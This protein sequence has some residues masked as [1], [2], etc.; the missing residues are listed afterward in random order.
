MNVD[1]VK[2]L[3]TKP[4]TS[5]RDA[6]HIAVVSLDVATTVYP[7]QRVGVEN[8]KIDPTSALLVGIVDPFL[9]NVPVVPGEKCFLY[10]FPGTITSLMHVW[11]HPDVP[12]SND[13]E[14]LQKR[15]KEL[16]SRNAELEE[17][18]EV[19]EDKIKSLEKSIVGE[20]FNNSQEARKFL[21]EVC[22][23]H[24]IDFH[25]LTAA[26]ISRGVFVQQGSTSLENE[27][28]A[29][30]ESERKLLNALY[31][32]TNVSKGPYEYGFFSCSC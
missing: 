10:L 8:G 22:K 14:V 28:P 30:S 3:G 19:K 15:I 31:L 5:I 18:F 26:Y 7:G 9:N 12:A 1:V 29:D 20:Y 25:A 4:K 6:V 21:E 32:V 17:E 23:D 11:T 2:M 24:C 16:E 13:V 27:F